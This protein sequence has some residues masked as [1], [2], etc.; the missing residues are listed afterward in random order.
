[1]VQLQ[2]P[3][4]FISASTL[5]VS[6]RRTRMQF[7]LLTTPIS[8]SLYIGVKLR[9]ISR[10]YLVIPR[11]PPDQRAAA[12]SYHPRPQTY[13]KVMQ[14]TFIIR[15][16]RDPWNLKSSV[17]SWPIPATTWSN[18]GSCCKRIARSPFIQTTIHPP[19]L[20]SPSAPHSSVFH[21][22]TLYFFS[23]KQSILLILH[24]T[25]DRPPYVS[26]LPLFQQ[27]PLDAMRYMMRPD[28]LPHARKINKPAS[29]FVLLLAGGHAFVLSDP[30]EWRRTS[31]LG[32]NTRVC[33]PD[34]E[35]SEPSD[36]ECA[37]KRVFLEY[38]SIQ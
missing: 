8:G 17:N 37:E 36:D 6:R 2:Y 19:T 16:E 1:M 21:L 24:P 14:S 18:I 25:T 35:P 15:N 33:V 28:P 7:N 26:S 38:T 29:R 5:L 20:K 22:Y 4:C 9:K 13:T 27:C 30:S 34:Q 11:V 31:Q 12:D 3:L 32:N 23:C 10:S